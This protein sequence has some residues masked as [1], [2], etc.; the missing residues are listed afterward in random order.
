MVTLKFMHLCKF[1]AKSCGNVRFV[2]L[3]S[4]SGCYQFALKLSYT[5]TRLAKSVKRNRSL[6]NN[7]L[8]CSQL[9]E[10]RMN[11]HKKFRLWH[12]AV[13]V[14][15]SSSSLCRNS[16]RHRIRTSLRSR[17][18]EI[19][20]YSISRSIRIGLFI[21]DSSSTWSI[22]FCPLLDNKLRVTNQPRRCI[23]ALISICWSRENKVQKTVL[24]LSTLFTCKIWWFNIPRIIEDR[25]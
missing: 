9:E 21:M 1:R 4:S 15:S 7:M 13:F 25:T 12:Q 10:T 17:V 16:I 14:T 3:F 11:K 5:Y 8:K 24:T 23:T 6:R 2:A 19:S 20:R 22:R 18:L